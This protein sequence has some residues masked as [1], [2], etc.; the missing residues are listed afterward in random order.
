[1]YAKRAGR[2]WVVR[3]EPDNVQKRYLALG[4]C[5]VEPGESER[6]GWH[7]NVEY[8]YESNSAKLDQVESKQL[9][10]IAYCGGRID[11]STGEER[12]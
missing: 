1:M 12:I 11:C 10:Y 8:R 6:A 7:Y 2:S 4:R 5:I 3:E 9:I